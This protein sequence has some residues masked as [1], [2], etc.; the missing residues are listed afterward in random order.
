MEVKYERKSKVLCPRQ[1]RQKRREALSGQARRPV[2]HSHSMVATGFSEEKY[3]SRTRIL[4]KKHSSSIRGWMPAADCMMNI[5]GFIQCPDMWKNELFYTRSLSDDCSGH[6][7]NQI[8]AAI[9][10]PSEQTVPD[11]ADILKRQVFPVGIFIV[12]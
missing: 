2:P 9:K 6:Q 1:V 11:Q 8:P 7:V 3:R 4:Q 5:T 12:Q 10:I